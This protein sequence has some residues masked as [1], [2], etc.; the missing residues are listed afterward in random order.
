MTQPEA[1]HVRPLVTSRTRLNSRPEYTFPPPRPSAT[2]AARA[3]IHFLYPSSAAE[4]FDAAA[5]ALSP[6]QLRR[7]N[8]LDGYVEARWLAS[9]ATS[10]RSAAAASSE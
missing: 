10:A 7:M 3:V 2:T 9:S 8:V 6:S 4:R 5:N 1:A